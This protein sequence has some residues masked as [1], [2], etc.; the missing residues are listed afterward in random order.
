[1]RDRLPGMHKPGGGRQAQCLSRRKFLTVAGSAGVVVAASQFPFAKARTAPARF[2]GYPFT[3][4]VAS[5]DPDVGRRGAVDAARAVAA[6]GQRRDAGQGDRGAV[7]GRQGRELRP[8]RRP[9]RG[10]RHVRRRALGARR[11]AGLQAG[12]R[13]LLPLQGGTGRS[14]RSGR[15]KTAPSGRDERAGVRVRELP[16]VR[17]RLLHGLQ[18]HG[19]GGPGPGHPR[20]R[21][22][23]RV[24]LELVHGDGRQ[25]A[26]RTPTTRSSTSPTTAS[27]TRSTRPTRTCRP[28][29]PRSRGW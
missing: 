14:A 25:R 23:L 11:A 17:A 15:T 2:T 24:R 9:R 4:G 3:L 21:L 16:A 6:G 1:M 8:R 10:A 19:A 5:G 28:R 27:A 20:R 12:L 22:H 7:G 26:R 13:V 18:A 29:T